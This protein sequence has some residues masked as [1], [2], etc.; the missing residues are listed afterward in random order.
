M[1]DREGE[2]VTMRKPE[3]F[4]WNMTH[5]PATTKSVVLLRNTLHSSNTTLNASEPPTIW[6]P[7]RDEAKPSNSENCQTTVSVLGG[8]AG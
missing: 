7:H 8:G 6:V 4:F 5:S 1:R 2:G 3:G